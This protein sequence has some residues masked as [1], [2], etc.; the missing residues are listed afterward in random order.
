MKTLQLRRFYSNGESTVGELLIK[1]GITDAVHLCYVLEDE[2]RKTKVMHETCIPEGTY[3]VGIHPNAAGRFVTAYKKRWDWHRGVMEL[4]NVPGFT[5]VLIHTGNR[6]DHTSGCLLV[7][8]GLTVTEDEST[9]NGSRGAY[10]VL[11]QKLIDSAENGE[12]EIEIVTDILESKI[13][14]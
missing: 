8:N 6:D 14:P 3:R 5:D 7:G 12:L 4:K 1:T 2:V 11:Y 10:A 13:K 9:V